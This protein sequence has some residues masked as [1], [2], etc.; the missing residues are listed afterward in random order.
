MGITSCPALLSQVLVAFTVELDNEF[1][2]RMAEAWFPAA[3]LS[4]VMWLNLMRFLTPAATSVG[5]V[6][7]QSLL[8]AERIKLQLGCLERWGYIFF[9]KERREDW[10]SGRGIRADSLVRLTPLGRKAIEIWSPLPADIERRWLK[11][12]GNHGR[13]PLEAIA[14]QLTLALPDGFPGIWPA[15]EKYPDRVPRSEPGLSLPVLL[16]R[17]LLAFTLEFDAESEAPL[18]LCANTLRI[19]GEEPV[20]E[21]DIPRLTGA[22]PETSGLGW[23]IKPYVRVE[24]DPGRTRG[25]WIFLTAKGVQARQGYQKLVGETEKRW[26]VRFGE[27]TMRQL[28]LSLKNL[29][30]HQNGAAMVEGLTPPPGVLRAGFL[31]PALGRRTVGPAA[32]QRMRDLVA[33]TAEFMRDPA[34]TLPH[35][36]LWDMNRGFGP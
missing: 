11:R 24:R 25:K 32:R 30:D 6:V 16:A 23:Q 15:L 5:S 35:H 3:R 20:R 18:A 27:E 29:F 26:G 4:L 17:L 31:V 14:A 13:E 8:P 2:R 33:Q 10:G 7:Q 28:V 1:E 22:S 21:A 9:H 34:G 36:P 12:F 19:L